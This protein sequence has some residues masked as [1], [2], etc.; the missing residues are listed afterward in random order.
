MNHFHNISYAKNVTKQQQ[1]QQTIKQ[2][3]KA[4]I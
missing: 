3:K 2:I 4:L 1:Q